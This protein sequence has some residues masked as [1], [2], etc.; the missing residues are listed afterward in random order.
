MAI[1]STTGFSHFEI[2]YGRPPPN[3][4][5]YIA[6]STNLEALET[7]LTSRDDILT[8]LKT[9]WEK[10][11]RR[12]KKNADCQRRNIFFYIRDWVYVKLQPY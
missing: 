9:N 8:A 6:R 7:T 2:V 5:R 12:M 1:H 3:I 4:Q 11:Q 10:A